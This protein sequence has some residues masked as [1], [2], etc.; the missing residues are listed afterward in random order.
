MSIKTKM[1]SAVHGFNNLTNVNLCPPAQL[2]SSTATTN[3]LCNLSLHSFSRLSQ[4]YHN[5]NSYW[6]LSC[7]SLIIITH[8]LRLFET[9][10][11]QKVLHLLLE[12]ISASQPATQVLGSDCSS[13]MRPRNIQFLPG[14]IE[15]AGTHS[16]LP[17]AECGYSE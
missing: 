11:S 17:G 1:I 4:H 15:C 8:Q 13:A 12:I 9:A 14:E 7:Y 3:I 6:R 5:D 16:P 10:N 2:L